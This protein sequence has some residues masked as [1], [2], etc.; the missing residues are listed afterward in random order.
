[1]TSAT[2]DI[3]FMQ[4]ALTLARANLGRVWPNPSVGCVIVKNNEIIARGATAV[5]GRPHAEVVALD[6]AGEDAFGSTAYVTLEPCSHWGVSPPCVEALLE[7]GVSRVV[8]ALQDP[9]PRVKGLGLEQLREASVQVDIGVCEKEAHDVNAGYFHRIETGRPLV[10][11]LDVDRIRMG[12][13]FYGGSYYDATLSELPDWIASE[14]QKP[15]GPLQIVV[16]DKSVAPAT[17]KEKSAVEREA[18]WLVVTA[19]RL[20]GRIEILKDYVGEIVEVET[21]EDGQPDLE[22]VLLEL[23]RRGLTRLVVE[24]ESQMAA[25]LKAI[26]ES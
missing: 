3:A 24:D 8:A 9:D 25:K 6:E 13:L 21:G 12:D 15:D 26:L 18:T 20:P 19:G 7:S 16:D 17:L 1:M 5:G 14:P 11:F 4:E 22:A 2:D 23:G 10:T